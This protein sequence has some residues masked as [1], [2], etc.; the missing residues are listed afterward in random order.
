MKSIG[1]K[2]TKN[3][4][5]LFSI[6][7]S[8]QF[9]SYIPYLKIDG[10]PPKLAGLLFAIYIVILFIYRK[11]SINDTTGIARIVKWTIVTI[12]ISFIPAYI[13]WNQSVI[14]TVKASIVLS[15]GLFL[16]LV[17]HKWQYSTKAL[18]SVL[19]FLSVVWVIL[20]IGQQFTYPTFWFSGR[21]LQNNS[22][23]ERMG[24]WRFYIWGVDVV[25][26]SFSYWLFRC[27]D[28]TKKTNKNMVKSVLIAILL[29]AGL[30]CYGSRKHIFA[31]LA[32]LAYSVLT[33]KGKRK[34]VYVCIAL[35]L[36]LFL[37]ETFFAGYAE[38][39]ER[40]NEA[41]GEGEDFIRY[42]S[43]Q[44][45]LFDFSNSP[46]YP[47]WG[48]GLEGEGSLLKGQLERLADY[49]LYQADVGIIG[50]YSKFGLLGVSAI[51]WY[52]YIFLRNWKFI[53][54]WFKYFFI[55]KMFLI[56][57]DFW[58]IWSVGMMA[59]AVFLYMLDQ[60]IKKNKAILK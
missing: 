43:A 47:L 52:I 44:Y 55:M 56:I 14:S 2:T 39:S 35:L 17:L 26:I 24:I 34:Y 21:F 37:F 20:E 18:M 12:F 23:N 40:A 4:L 1:E 42:I 25:M 59:Y 9:W 58:A 49:G 51:V 8:M 30:L 13:E 11:I 27:I 22:V 50:Y 31:T 38:M 16:F 48:A 5:V 10:L 46:L 28:L 3:V 54:K 36:L 53:D 33:V 6:L 15:Y 7:L 60:N 41:Q 32:I 19:T 29:M 57:F 45:F